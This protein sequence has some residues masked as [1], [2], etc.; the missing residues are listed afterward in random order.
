LPGQ[1]LT[2]WTLGLPDQFA[3]RAL[4]YSLTRPFI[5]FPTGPLL[6]SANEWL[7][8][9]FVIP[10]WCGPMPCSGCVVQSMQ[11]IQNFSFPSGHF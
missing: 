10:I 8:C 6:H 5:K 4:S 3:A 7:L 2:D 9:L 11:W 1:A